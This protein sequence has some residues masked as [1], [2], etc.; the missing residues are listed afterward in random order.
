MIHLNFI[1]FKLLLLSILTFFVPIQPLLLLIIAFIIT[2]TALGLYRSYKNKI[3]ITSDRFSN[4]ISKFFLYNGAVILSYLL[5]VFILGEFTQF[6]IEIQYLFT[7]IV[8]LTIIFAEMKSIDENFKDI[9]GLHLWDT[10]KQM[11]K[12]TKEVKEDIKKSL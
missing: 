2:D 6:I 5:D 8:T 7:K 11:V 10:F 4:I 9:T 1:N 3:A 12:R